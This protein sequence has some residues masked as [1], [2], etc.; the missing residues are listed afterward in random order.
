MELDYEVLVRDG[1]SPC[2]SAAASLSLIIVDVDD[3]PPRFTQTVYIFD[4]TE[5][6]DRGT[7][8]GTVS[9]TDDDNWP[10]NTV[11]LISCI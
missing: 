10:F 3:C 9:A 2:L 6:C 11:R 5:N 7:T 8:V 4:V 1:G